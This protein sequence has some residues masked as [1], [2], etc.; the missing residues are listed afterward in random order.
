MNSANGSVECGGNAIELVIERAPAADG[1]RFAAPRAERAQ[2]RRSA[3]SPNS[4]ASLLSM[5]SR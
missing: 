3:R 2:K 4:L 1:G 5:R